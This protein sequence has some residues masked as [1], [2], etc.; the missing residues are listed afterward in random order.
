MSLMPRPQS[1]CTSRESIIENVF[2]LLTRTSSDVSYMLCNDLD[3]E[4]KVIFCT[5]NIEF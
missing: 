5:H 2:E 1:T 3:E 4:N